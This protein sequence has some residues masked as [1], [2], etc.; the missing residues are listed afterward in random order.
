MISL[1]SLLRGVAVLFVAVLAATP[2]ALA[3]K[4]GP[5]PPPCNNCWIAGTGINGGAPVDLLMRYTLKTG[6]PT[7]TYFAAVKNGSSPGLYKSTN[8]GKTWTLV[9][10]FATPYSLALVRHS[11][12]VDGRLMVATSQG[13]YY[14]DDLRKWV[15]AAGGLPTNLQVRWVGYVG[16]N[17]GNQVY[18]TVDPSRFIPNS[19]VY[20]SLDDGATW[21]KVV[22]FAFMTGIDD[23]IGCQYLPTRLFASIRRSDGGPV[24]EFIYSDDYGA[25]WTAGSAPGVIDA[26]DISVDCDV[27][28]AAR[29]VYLA[30][31]YPPVS[32]SSD[33]GA[34]WATDSNGITASGASGWAQPDDF[35][36][37]ATLGAGIWTRGYGQLTWTQVDTTGLTDLN[38]TCSA[39]FNNYVA[40]T[41]SGIFYYQP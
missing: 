41:P 6:S 25:T 11:V 30:A 24:G 33:F 7:I 37:V 8:S 16:S 5:P 19:G 23:S 12:S 10:S 39:L 28:G 36:R 32:K 4:P 3:G 17:I 22:S 38:I 40:G 34:T 9:K 2:A 13:L 21:T 1:R 15:K 35:G 14:S 26:T 20:R 31:E 18:A 27:S 29:N